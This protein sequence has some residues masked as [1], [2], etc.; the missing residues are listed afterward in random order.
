[1]TE[2]AAQDRRLFEAER[3]AE[4]IPALKKVAEGETGDD[5]GNKQTAQYNL[6]VACRR[7]SQCRTRR[8][9]ASRSPRAGYRSTRPRSPRRRKLEE[10]RRRADE[11]RRLQSQQEQRAEEA[12]QREAARKAQ[13]QAAHR[14]QCQTKCMG[15]AECMSACASQASCR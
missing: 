11:A 3:W 10:A 7:Q 6:A 1:M 12:R 5:E 4:A 9:S 14:E 15:V 2:E 13:C 8:R